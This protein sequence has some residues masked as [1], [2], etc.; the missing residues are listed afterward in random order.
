[1]LIITTDVV[2]ADPLIPFWLCMLV[3]RVSHTTRARNGNSGLAQGM[4]KISLDFMPTEE[5]LLP[6]G[7]PIGETITW[8]NVGG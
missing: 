4:N 3:L 7:F 6:E 8:M 1:M 5:I 2:W